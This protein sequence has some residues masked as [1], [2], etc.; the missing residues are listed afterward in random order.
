VLELDGVAT[1]VGVGVGVKEGEGTGVGIGFGAAIEIPLFQTS[2][3]PLFTQ[4]NFL[5]FAVAVLP[6]FLHTSPVLTAATAFMGRR[7]R[8][9]AIKDPSH[10]FM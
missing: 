6:A 2:F 9:K 10:F 3:L 8:V 7:N 4:V 5:P 1:G